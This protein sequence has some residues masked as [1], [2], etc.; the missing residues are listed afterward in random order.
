VIEREKEKGRM[1]KRKMERETRK[2]VGDEK[3]TGTL[4]SGR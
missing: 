4:D 1:K 3:P 2:A